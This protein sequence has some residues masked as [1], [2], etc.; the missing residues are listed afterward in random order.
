MVVYVNN[1]PHDAI[2]DLGSDVSLIDQEITD[3]LAGLFI[4]SSVMSLKL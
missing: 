4:H 3:N 2:L 1:Q